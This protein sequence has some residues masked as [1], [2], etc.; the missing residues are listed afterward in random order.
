M[1]VEANK[2]LV[3]KYMEEGFN[4]GNMVIFDEAFDPDFLD[5]NGFAYQKPGLT[6]V[7]R[8]Y[9]LFRAAFPDLSVTIEDMVA[10]ED[11]VV[12]RSVLQAAH[13]NAFLGLPPTGRHI[14]VESISIFRIAK[15]KILERWGL[16]TDF[17]RQL[18]DPRRDTV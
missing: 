2:V 15:G 5:H 1:S 4:S 9:E 6:E 12:V 3:R 13:L 16:N 14:E 7:K 10:E 8:A 17:M 18:G 11:R